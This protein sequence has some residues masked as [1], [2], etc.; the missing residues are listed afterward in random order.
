MSTAEARKFLQEIS[1]QVL[2][3]EDILR[4]YS[5]DASSYQIIPEIVIVPKNEKDVVTAVKFAKKFQKSITVRG[6]GTGL[7]GNSLN[8]GIILDMRNLDLVKIKRDSVVVGPGTRKGELDKMLKRRGKFFPPN[9]SIGRYCSV[10]GMLGNNSSGSRSLKYGSTIDN[11]LEITFVDGN[12][13]RITLPQDSKIGKKILAL[14]KKIDWT[15]IPSTTKNS[16]GY[17]IDGVMSI[18][19]THKV[20]V[21]SEGTL[22]IIVS[23]ELKIKDIPKKRTLYII[24]YDS[25][26]NAVEDCPC[27]LKTKPAAVEFVDVQTLKHFE[28]ELARNVTCMLFVEYDSRLTGT[29][30]KISR[31]ITGRIRQKINSEREIQKWWEMRNMSLYYSLELTNPKHTIPQI[32]EDAAVPVKNLTALFKIIENLNEKFKTNTIMYGHAGS[33][34]IHLR[35]QADRQTQDIKRIATYYFTR[36][37]RLGGSI[38]GEHGDGLARTW[39][40]RRQYGQENYK[41]F[42]QLKGILDPHNIL[43]PGKIVSKAG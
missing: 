33:G 37:L 43:N 28:I 12:G 25:P 15:R 16:S 3:D 42:K 24:E 29:D 10:G 14:A 34:N 8:D 30:R 38:S 27:I 5:V 26:K 23:A 4:F 32:L 35:L 17:R 41:I 36:V 1:G 19:D 13:N 18:R 21:G 22:G 7:V 6:A 20:I 9:P 40:V 39:F 11:V 2:W 31:A